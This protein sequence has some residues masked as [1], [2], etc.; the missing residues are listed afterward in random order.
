[1]KATS[2]VVKGERREIF[3][4]PITDDG[5]KKSAK[6]LIKVDLV[7]NEYVLVDQVTPKEEEGGE[8]QV[9]Y[10]NG[11]FVNQVTLKEIRNRVN[12]NL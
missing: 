9:I 10:K 4:D 5:V 2:V 8:L 6:G 12:E 11:K 7:N 3:K 1:M